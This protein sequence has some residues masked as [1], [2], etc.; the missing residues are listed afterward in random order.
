[1]IPN[2]YKIAGELTPTV[3]H[4]AA[5]SLATQALSI[6]GDHSDVMATRATG[7]AMLASNS[8][9]EAMDLAAVAHAATLEARVPVLHFFDGFRTSHEVAKIQALQD[10]D[11]RA[12]VDDRV[13]QASRARALS[14]EHPVIRGTAQNV[15]IYFQGREAANAYYAA[16]PA[17]IQS[18]MDHLAARTGR[19][20]H[21]VDYVG[22]P[23]AERVL[24]LMGSG[25][26]AAEETANFLNGRG[27]RVGVVKLRLYRPFPAD[28][29]IAALPPTT[30]AMAV[31]D[32]T[33]EPGSAGEP[34]YVDVVTAVSEALSAEQ[35][36]FAGAPRIVGGRYGLGSKEFTPAM[37]KAVFDELASPRPRNHFTI[38][39]HDDVTHT[40]LPWDPGFSTEP[41][42]TVRAIFYGLGADGTVGANKNSI[43]I[44][45]EETDAY[46]QGYFVYDSKKSGSVTVSHLR[47]GPRPIHAPYLIT[48]AT[49]VAHPVRQMRARLPARGDPG[50]G[51]RARC[52]RR[53]PRELQVGTRAMARVWRRAL[54][55]AGV[56]RGLHG[57]RTLRGSLPRQEQ[58]RGEAPGHRH[59][60]PGSDSRR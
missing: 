39:I 59:G 53:R 24:V 54:H 42:D 38:G 2:M 8:V 21:L 9:Q 51:L 25:A 4:V 17:I 34:L 1:M 18:A 47:F 12:L 7:V 44:I 10:D 57:L 31:L 35:G 27:E 14:P 43:K 29:L 23:D 28:A 45:G 37:I 13:V 11:L 60:A 48:R 55:A 30:R 50:Q 26:E 15:D 56:A 41:R 20:Y 19:A 36:P 6:F 5:R 49:F 16:F 32:R 46:A 3:F 58:E 22:A 40:S 33:K 52:A